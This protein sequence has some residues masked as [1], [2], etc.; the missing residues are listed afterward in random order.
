MKLRQT[1]LQILF[2]CIFIICGVYLLNNCKKETQT[3]KDFDYLRSVVEKNEKKPTQNSDEEKNINPIDIETYEPNGMLS[4]YYSLYEMNND[5]AGWVKIE[6]TD[7]DYPVM[8]NSESN[9]YYLHRNFEKKN[10][11]N[12]IPFMDYQCTPNEFSDNV[13][14]YGHNLR[15]GTMFHDL[16]EY[17]SKEFWETHSIIQYDTMYNRCK[18]EI[19]A[20]FRTTVG[21]E[22]E[23]KYYEFVNA[24]S[25]EEFDEYVSLCINNSLYSTGIIPQYSE[26]LLTLSTCSYNTNNERFVVVGRQITRQ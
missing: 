4:R 6:G 18:Y 1:L 10:N 21:S 17:K 15:S 9:A 22:N 25:K 20:V 11:S 2:L 12:G 8:Y 23:F 19:F 3:E 24:E 7:I 26:T 16:L 14:I 13:I 5:M